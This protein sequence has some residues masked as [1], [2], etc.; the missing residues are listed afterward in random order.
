MCFFI[1]IAQTVYFDISYNANA[2]FMFIRCFEGITKIHSE[3]VEMATGD[4]F[5]GDKLD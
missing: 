3:M 4:N 2:Y 5:T 1:K